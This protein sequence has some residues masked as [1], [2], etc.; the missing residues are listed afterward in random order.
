MIIC[1]FVG[2]ILAPMHRFLILFC[3]LAAALPSRAQPLFN[4]QNLDG[5]SGDP[6]LWRVENGV[7]I[8]ETN[9]SDKSISTNSFLIWQGGKPGDFELEFQARVTA[10]N[11]SGVQYRSEVLDPNAWVVS[12]YQMDLHPNPS[13]LGMLYEERGRGIACERGQRVKLGDKPTVTGTLEVPEVVLGDW[14]SYRIV[15]QGHTLR[16]FINGKLAAEIQDVQ[17]DKRASKGVIAL[18]VHAGPAMKAEFKGLRISSGDKMQ[19]DGSPSADWIWK[20]EEPS[21]NEKV[22]FRREFQL[23]PHIAS[24]SVT[25]ACD[26]SHRLFVNG[27]DVGGGDGWSSVHQYDVIAHLKPGSRNIIAVEG[28]NQKGQ[29]GLAMRLGVKLDD[30]KKLF[31]VSDGF[32]RCSNVAGSDWQKLDF[33]AD[34]WAKAVVVAKMGE[35]PWGTVIPPETE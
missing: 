24:A 4:G 29:A 25:L 5:W 27:E 30:G 33:P 22:F 8:G 7:L 23:P 31:I 9:D 19:S 1:D 18:Q 3:L 28:T 21:E 32:W 16:H 17:P 26:D 15:A 2:R 14:N 11:N 20:C 6:R 34:S 12:G 13:Y 10:S 35:A